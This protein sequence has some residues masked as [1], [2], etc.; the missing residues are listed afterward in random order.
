MSSQFE[1]SMLKTLAKYSLLC[2]LLISI[3]SSQLCAGQQQGQQRQ[4]QVT[5]QQ[6]RVARRGQEE[7]A[8]IIQFD[9]ENAYKALK[10]VCDLGPRISGSEA[11]KQQQ[12]GLEKYFEE[13]GAEVVRQN[14][15]V[16]HPVNR[17]RT[18]LTNLIVHFHPDR[19]Q[20]ILICCHYDTRPYPDMDA[21][22][23]R[24]V[25]HGAN[26]GASG[27]GLLVELG[28]HVI[29]L[30]GDVGIDFVFFDAEEFIYDRQ[31]DELFVGSTYFARDYAQRPPDYVYRRGVLVDMVGD[32]SLEIYKEKNSLY[33]ARDL[34]EQIWATAK[35]L[36]IKEFKQRTRHTI[37][38]DHLPL[39]EI[40]KIPTCDIIDFDFPTPRD[41]NKYWHT[42]NDIPEN[43]SADSLAK[44]GT[45]LV[46]WLNEVV[47]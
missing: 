28:R 39:N 32:A 6:D 43:C 3:G 44:V 36:G 8:N 17:Q 40:A 1:K 23:P 47:K 33:H 18:T 15:D 31:R 21:Y 37:R 30:P 26:D 35:E 41:R 2:G 46:H 19:E 42:T 13:L 24:G 9:G 12:D 5:V 10:W 27:V 25:F 22:N 29:N 14:F 45:V 4:D 7:A 16:A 34:T 20:R 38:D 11:M